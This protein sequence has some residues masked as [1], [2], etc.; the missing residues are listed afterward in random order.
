[1]IPKIR[2]AGL[3]VRAG[4][5]NVRIGMAEDLALMLAGSTGSFTEIRA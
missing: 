2:N 3:A 1:M 4:V 5:Q